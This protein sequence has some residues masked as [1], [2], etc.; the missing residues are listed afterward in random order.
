MRTLI[1]IAAMAGLGIALGLLFAHPAQAQIYVD[2]TDD[3]LN[4]DGDCS[5]REAVQAANTNTPVDNCVDNSG[6]YNTIVLDALM[7]TLSIPG[8]NEDDNQTGDLDIIESVTLVG[9]GPWQ[10]IIYAADIDRALH[11][12]SGSTIIRDLTITDG[13]TDTFFGDGGCILVNGS[14]SL[15]NVVV[16]SCLAGN[17]GGGIY[18]APGASLE[19]Y[20]CVIVENGAGGSGGGIFVANR[21][22]V[23]IIQNTTIRDNYANQN[24]GGIFNVGTIWDIYNTT[25][26]FNRAEVGNGGGIFNGS[27]G[28]IGG[29]GP[30]TVLN[31]TISSNSAVFGGGIF[32]AGQIN[33]VINVTIAYNNAFQGGGIRNVSGGSFEGIQSSIIANSIN[34]GDCSN[35][36]FISSWGYNILSDNTCSSA[37]TG[38]GDLLGTDPMLGPLQNNGGPTNT[39]ALLPGSPAIDHVDEWACPWP[40]TDQRGFTRPIDGDGDS[41]LRCDSG[42]FEFEPLT[43]AD[44]SITKSDDPDPVGVGEDLT[45]T[46]VVTNNGPDATSSEVFVSDTL[47]PG[48]DFVSVETTQGWCDFTPPDFIECNLGILDPG[49]TVTITVTVRPTEAIGGEIIWNCAQAFIIEGNDPNPDNNES[50]VDTRVQGIADLSVTKSDD[51]DPVM[52]GS[53][54]TYTITV[55]NNGPNAATIVTLTDTLPTGVTFVSASPGCIFS[56]PNTVICAL[57]TLSVNDSVDVTIVVRPNTPGIITN[58]AEVTAIEE[59][60]NLNDNQ[61]TEET[62]VQGVAD[63]SVVKTDQ[64]DPVVVGQDLSYTLVVTN[65]GPSL[66]TNVVLADTLPAGVIFV[67][68]IPSQGTCSHTAGV[69][70]CPLGTLAVGTQVTVTITIQPTVDNIGTI[71]NVASVTSDAIDPTPDDNQ[72]DEPTQVLSGQGIIRG[73]KWLDIDGDGHKASYEPFLRGIT[74]TVTGTDVWGNSVNLSAVTD[75]Q[76]RFVFVNLPPGTYTVC[77]VRPDVISYQTFP[78]TGPMCPN[79]E[80]PGW[81]IVLGDG[82]IRDIAFGNVFDELYFEPLALSRE[83]QAVPHREGIEFRPQHAFFVQELRVEIFDLQ[84]RLIY[85]SPWASESVLWKLQNQQGQRVARGVYLYIVTVRAPDGAVIRSRV[86]KLLVK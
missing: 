23:G 69:V 11:I 47:P 82:E 38:P 29:S 22:Y 12:R 56:A 32:N 43:G 3:E 75:A 50:C 17:S 48:V 57:G 18:V 67:S 42:A 20:G 25:I 71:I 52:A 46:I 73:F 36:G 44:V 80:F 58:T 79:S 74:I 19:L 6:F 30:A 31:T 54:L 41:I 76:G 77:E 1:I 83:I 14:L 2:T 49:Q 5:L 13:S 24:G 70:T 28:S 86:Q 34:G 78:R 84:G 26:S 60:P 10:T 39:H 53:D 51:P 21:A 63:L 68:A 27:S 16:Y 61:D 81:S 37:F 33:N 85:R 66:A 45:Y 7:Y 72:D 55:T 8:F 64:T 62:E 35:A 40:D 15:E 9:A 59:D 4:T 65:N